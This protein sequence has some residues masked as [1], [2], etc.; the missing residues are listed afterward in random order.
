MDELIIKII[1]IGD[2]NAG[3]Q[4]LLKKFN[5]KNFMEKASLSP[6]GISNI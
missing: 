4:E 5:Y 3:K 6:L 2:S 1:E